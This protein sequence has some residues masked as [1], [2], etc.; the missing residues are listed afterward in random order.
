[1]QDPSTELFALEKK[2]WQALV[3]ADTDTAI[4]QLCEPAFTVSAHGLTKFDHA[5][6]RR[7]AEQGPMVVRSFRLS[8]MEA[9][10]PGKDTAVVS[11]KA[12]Q[13]LSPRGSSE[14]MAQHMLDTSTWVRDGRTWRCVMHTEAPDPAA[15]EERP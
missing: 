7:M 1:M 9:S 13:E 2:F 8:D 12:W 10:F 6:Y 5:G 14:R 4:A 3:D 15:A 11:Y